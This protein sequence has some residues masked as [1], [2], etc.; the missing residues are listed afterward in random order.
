MGP[1]HDG[2]DGEDGIEYVY[3]GVKSFKLQGARDRR[4]FLEPCTLHLLN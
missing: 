1:V 4:T 2:G 3:V